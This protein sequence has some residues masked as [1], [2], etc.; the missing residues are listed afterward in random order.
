MLQL[1]SL[2]FDCRRFQSAVLPPLPVSTESVGEWSGVEV[3]IHS[4]IILCD[5]H[6]CKRVVQTSGL[7]Y[8]FG[9]YVQLDGCGPSM[10]STAPE[11]HKHSRPSVPVPSGGHAITLKDMLAKNDVF[12]LGYC[13]YNAL[14]GDS[15]MAAGFPDVSAAAFREWDLP[16]LPA[17]I[18]KPTKALL[19][20]MVACDPTRRPTLR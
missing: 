10:G 8:I 7:D 18:S 13:M 19:V 2:R 15:A 16:E 11:I 12:A 3:G 9:E 4:P 6:H 17:H 14:L 20:R 5:L 1:H